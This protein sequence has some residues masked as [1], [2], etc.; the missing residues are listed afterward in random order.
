MSLEDRIKSIADKRGIS[1]EEVVE[2]AIKR[3]EEIQSQID[4]ALE[5]YKELIANDKYPLSEEEV[6]EHLERFRKAVN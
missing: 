3:E 5:P 1:P 4:D 6:K 2:I